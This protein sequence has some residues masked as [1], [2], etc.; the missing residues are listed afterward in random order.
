MLNIVEILIQKRF[1]GDGS[2]HGIFLDCI[3]SNFDGNFVT[4]K[5]LTLVL[6][7]LE[8]GV[9]PQINICVGISYHVVKSISEVGLFR[10]RFVGGLQYE[11]YT[12]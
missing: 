12:A 2:I 8:I 10:C 7:T 6:Y 9:N 3:L 11:E 5:L 1:H 4:Y